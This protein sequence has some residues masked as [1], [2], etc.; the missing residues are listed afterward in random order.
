M[1]RKPTVTTI[2]ASPVG[3]PSRFNY[4]RRRRGFGAS[5][6]SSR[7]STGTTFYEGSSVKPSIV[8]T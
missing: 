4:F 5:G 8:G 6:A 3:A 7:C 2:V 1:R